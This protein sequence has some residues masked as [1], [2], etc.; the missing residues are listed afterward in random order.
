MGAALDRRITVEEYPETEWG[1]PVKR[2]YVQ[3]R[4]HALAG[5]SE[6]HPRRVTNLGGLL[7]SAARKTACRV[8]A[9]DMKLRAGPDRFYCPDVMVVCDPQDQEEHYK[10]RPCFV[11]EVLSPTTEGADRREQLLAYLEIPDP[12]G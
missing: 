1:S 6:R 11:A 3:G 7:W 10:A 2:G 8:S 9:A 4:V 5:A 12:R